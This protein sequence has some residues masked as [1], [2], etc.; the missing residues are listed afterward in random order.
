MPEIKKI[1]SVTHNSAQTDVVFIKTAT[2]VEN[3]TFE[4]NTLPNIKL[5]KISEEDT[6]VDAQSVNLGE[7]YIVGVRIPT[8]NNMS[9]SERGDLIVYGNDVA[10]YSI[11]EDGDLIYTNND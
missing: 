4:N 9:I 5:V 3:Y 2:Q 10:N 6:Q 8:E 1:K 7:L 11:N